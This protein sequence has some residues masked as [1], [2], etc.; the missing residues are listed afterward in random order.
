M[1]LVAKYNDV[2]TLRHE[3]PDNLEVRLRSKTHLSSAMRAKREIKRQ[4]GLG[5]V[6]EIKDEARE[7]VERVSGIASLD[8]Y[9]SEWKAY[10]WESIVE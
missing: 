8:S 5:T 2:C 1:D 7:I 3:R 4:Y 6:E 9:D 10:R